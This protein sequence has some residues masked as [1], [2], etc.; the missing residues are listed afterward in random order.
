MT[1]FNP[2]QVPRF[3]ELARRAF[4][5]DLEIGTVAP[6]IMFAFILEQD[7]GD[8][9][10]LKN[11]RLLGA[12]G[13]QGGLAANPSTIRFRTP[14]VPL[15]YIWTIKR[16]WFSANANTRITISSGGA[17]ANL[18]N[19]LTTKTPRDFRDSRFGATAADPVV[20][21]GANVVSGG[22][23]FFNTFVLNNQANEPYDQDVVLGPNTFIDVSLVDLN[24]G[25]SAAIAYLMRPS[26]DQ[27]LGP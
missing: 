23:E 25:L 21:S 11:E 26:R 3:A 16:I 15:G 10:F 7:R 24:I 4:G 27:E 14:A 2:H 22:A 5:E 8:W 1:D 6:E 13:V 18:A 12:S 9:A 19:V 20:V 17:S